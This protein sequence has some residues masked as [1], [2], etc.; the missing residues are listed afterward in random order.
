MMQ[1]ESTSAGEDSTFKEAGK[2]H[3]YAMRSCLAIYAPVNYNPG[4]SRAWEV[5]GLQGFSTVVLHS[6]RPNVGLLIP[7]KV[8]KVAD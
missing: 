2:I 7:A 1:K 3:S 5:P 4:Y 6:S 8:G